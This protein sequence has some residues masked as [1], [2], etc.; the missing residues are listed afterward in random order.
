[1]KATQNRVLSFLLYP[2]LVVHAIVLISAAFVPKF[3]VS[4]HDE[5][6]YFGAGS[7]IWHTGQVANRMTECH[8]PLTYYINSLLL[9]SDPVDWSKV[10]DW[11][12]DTKRTGDETKLHFEDSIGWDLLWQTEAAGRSVPWLFFRSRLPFVLIS[13][14][15]AWFLFT[16][17]RP[18]SVPMAVASTALYALSPLVLFIAPGIM[19]DLTVTVLITLAVI[20]LSHWSGH[21]KKRWA[22]IAGILTGL[23]LASKV[24]ALILGPIFLIAAF[25]GIWMKTGDRGVAIRRA[26]GGLV[27]SGVT[28]FVVL[29]AVYGFQIDTMKNIQE[30][31][32]SLPYQQRLMK[33]PPKTR[34]ETRFPKLFEVQLPAVSFYGPVRSAVLRRGDIR[35]RTT[36]E[37][38]LA[39]YRNT[40]LYPWT[41]LATYFPIAFFPF[42][43]VAAWLL[44]KR[45]NALFL[46][47][48]WMIVAAWPALYVAS[49]FSSKY[50]Y[51]SRHVFP[52]F[53]LAVVVSG[54]IIGKLASQKTLNVLLVTTIGLTALEAALFV[55]TSHPWSLWMFAVNT[56][57]VG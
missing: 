31:H 21:L 18:I 53:P 47:S 42:V 8:P 9:G 36:V 43:L 22:I 49:S 46:R 52:I 45:W 30:L 23:A 14:A 34:L 10:T 4:D 11:F 44:V 13:V 37:G 15:F 32:H 1:M 55:M 6:F 27:L 26:L 57:G 39:P 24:S 40:R 51:G 29:W 3:A 25:R 35:E 33:V 2:L 28:T 38:P 41:V 7:V 12:G 19:T 5:P 50:F 56:S 54:V 48:R 17:L 16:L 20:A